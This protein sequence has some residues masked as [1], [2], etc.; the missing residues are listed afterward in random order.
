M[1]LRTP[2]SVDELHTIL[3]E[4][5]KHHA[6]CVV[7]AWITPTSPPI[8]VFFSASDKTP[9]GAHELL[10]QCLSEITHPTTVLVEH[11]PGRDANPRS[12]VR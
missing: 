9:E 2:Q 10:Q 7:P 1:Q 12:W 11:L 8:Y 4:A 3:G 6:H 5:H